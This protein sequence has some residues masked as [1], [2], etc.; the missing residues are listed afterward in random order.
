MRE[1]KTPI[2]PLRPT[3]VKVKNQNH[4]LDYKAICIFSAIGFFL[5]T[6]TYFLDEKVLP[7]A[8][9]NTI[10]NN[11]FW[12]DSKPWFTWHYTPHDTDLKAVVHQ[13]SNLFEKIV[14]K[15]SK[16]KEVILP[17]SGGLDSRTQAVALHK[18][19]AKVASYSYSFYNGYKESKISEKIAKKCDF[20][21]AEFTVEKSYLWDKMSELASINQCYS[22]FTHPRQMAVIEE[23]AQLGNNFSLGHWGDVL[24]DSDGHPENLSDKELLKILKKKVL[25]KGGIELASALWENWKL[26]G[27]FETYLDKRISV[28]LTNIKIENTNAKLRAFKSLYW[29]PRWTSVNLSIFEDKHEINLPFYEDAMCEFICTIPEK[30]LA[31]RK[32]QIEYIKQTYPNVAKILWQDARPFN[33]YNHHLAKFPYNFPYRVSNKFKRVFES[34]LGKKFVQRNWE[35]QFLGKENRQ[36]LASH[37]LSDDFNKEVDRELV[38]KIINLFY[39]NDSVYYSH[40]V[41]M[42]L[43]LSVYFKKIK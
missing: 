2:I 17:L 37:I 21:F 25:K 34:L 13:F 14:E 18:I 39:E 22:E 9:V 31:D 24:F 1:I 3:F 8:T 23:I 7:P 19:G 4:D 12:V 5:D 29:A 32:V 30:I 40:A 42:L 38:K 10:D 41:S 27:D 33:L 6:D 35:L 15:Q 28:L 43:T 26:E 16:N 20:S 36:K 11:G